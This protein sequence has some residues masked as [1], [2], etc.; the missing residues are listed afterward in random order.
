MAPVV[1]RELSLVWPA[2]I[3]L[4]ERILVHKDLFSLLADDKSVALVTIEPLDRATLLGQ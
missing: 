4:I 3:G 2:S 1:E